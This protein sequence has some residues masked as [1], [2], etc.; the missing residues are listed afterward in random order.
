MKLASLTFSFGVVVDVAGVVVYSLL[1][2]IRR[3]H[4]SGAVLTSTH[5]LLSSAFSFHKMY[6]DCSFLFS[7]SGFSLVPFF[8]VWVVLSAFTFFN[9]LPLKKANF[10]GLEDNSINLRLQISGDR[11][12]VLSVVKCLWTPIYLSA[13]GWCKDAETPLKHG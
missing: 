10:Q 3:G 13:T 11:V 5:L 8:L 6:T 7:G 4:V 1:R 2:V 9:P 12:C